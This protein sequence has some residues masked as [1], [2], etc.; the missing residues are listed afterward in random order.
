M[1]LL[2]SLQLVPLKAQTCRSTN[3]TCI[4]QDYVTALHAVFLER[5]CLCLLI[6]KLEH[7]CK[8]IRYKVTLV[9]LPDHISDSCWLYLAVP[10]HQAC[11]SR[12]SRITVGHMKAH[13]T[14]VHIQECQADG[15]LTA[16]LMSRL[17][18]A[19]QCQK[20]YSSTSMAMTAFCC[21]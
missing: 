20:P 18:P 7:Y 21:T 9:E 5:N 19:L 16:K 4:L 2:N 15:I 14:N 6:L 11:K 10:I 17:K 1:M 13:R 3:M 12:R 8:A